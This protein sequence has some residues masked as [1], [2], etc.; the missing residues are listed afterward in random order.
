MVCCGYK[1]TYVCVGADT[2][3]EFGN[4]TESLGKS[5]DNWLSTIG[6]ESISASKGPFWFDASSS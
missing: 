5:A 6:E 4:D 2:G 1:K 3:I